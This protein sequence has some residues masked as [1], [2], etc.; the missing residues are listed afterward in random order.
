MCVLSEN[1]KK[2]SSFVVE[3]ESQSD[4]TVPYHLKDSSV[5]LDFSLMCHNLGPAFIQKP[6]SYIKTKL[7]K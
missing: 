7:F 5:Y 4:S 1:E 2:S 6:H 3:S